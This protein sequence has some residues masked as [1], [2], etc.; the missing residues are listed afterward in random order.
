MLKP[1]LKE[2]ENKKMLEKSALSLFEKGEKNN[3]VEQQLN[4]S[5]F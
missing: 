5:F 1:Y 3:Q 4:N 2:V